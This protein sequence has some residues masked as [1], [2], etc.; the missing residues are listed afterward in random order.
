M[1]SLDQ[2]Q[3]QRATQRALSYWESLR[4]GRRSPL[5]RDFRYDEELSWNTN[6]FLLK[7][8]SLTANSVFI[9]CGER[10]AQ[11][12]GGQPIRKT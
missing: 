10:A 3:E 8:D 11:S 1:R 4:G 6:L 9:L 7:E 5:F 12:F 2:G